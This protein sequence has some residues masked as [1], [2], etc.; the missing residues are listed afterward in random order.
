MDPAAEYMILLEQMMDMDT[1]CGDITAF[2]V[3][4]INP[5]LAF[6]GKVFGPDDGSWWTRFKEACLEKG[7][8][9]EQRDK[10]SVTVYPK[11]KAEYEAVKK[12]RQVER[13]ARKPW[14]KVFG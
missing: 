3:S 10:G 6:G 7:W 14:W 12:R 9:V 2:T 11:G 8:D 1:P 13:A 5:L 4:E